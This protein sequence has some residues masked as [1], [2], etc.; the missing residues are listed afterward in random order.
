M[1][2]QQD[3]VIDFRDDFLKGL[4]TDVRIEAEKFII[5]Q[6]NKFV[7]SVQEE[8]YLDL[9]KKMVSRIA[10]QL[11]S[12]PNGFL[13]VSVSYPSPATQESTKGSTT[14]GAATG[15][16]DNS[17]PGSAVVGGPDVA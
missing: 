8:F 3:N 17:A 16:P 14:E 11:I 10:I 2:V 7:A 4:E 13:G 5:G 9:A 6:I 15:T 12:K 1:K